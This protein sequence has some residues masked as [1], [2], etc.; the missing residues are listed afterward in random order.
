MQSY[1]YYEHSIY[2]ETFFQS[3]KWQKDKLHS[4]FLIWFL[5][6]C[7]FCAIKENNFINYILQKCSSSRFSK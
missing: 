7:A 3:Q 4:V 6:Y 1:K 2:H 5:E